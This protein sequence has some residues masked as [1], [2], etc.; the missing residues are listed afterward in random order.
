M[1]FSSFSNVDLKCNEATSYLINN[2]CSD[3]ILKAK[4]FEKS[5]HIKEV[6]IFSM[7]IEPIS[8]L[9]YSMCSTKLS[10][11]NDKVFFF[12]LSF[13]TCGIYKGVVG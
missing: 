9:T 7:G 6:Y 3:E 11:E 13:C 5:S 8:S 1:T 12:F 2:H 10:Y 4:K